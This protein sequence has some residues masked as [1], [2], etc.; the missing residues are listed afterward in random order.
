MAKKIVAIAVLVV[1]AIAVIFLVVF[2]QHNLN[3][4]NLDS[5]T[6][7]E[8]TPGELYYQGS[9]YT[10]KKNQEV[11]LLIGVDKFADDT[12]DYG[13]G[14]NAV[15]D[16]QLLVIFDK[17]TDETT[18][19]QLNRDTMTEITE[20]GLNNVEVGT[21][22]EQLALAYTYGSGGSDSCINIKKAVSNL[23]YGINIDYYAAITMD[24]LHF[25]NDDHG[26]VTLTVM[27]DLTPYDPDLEEGKVVTLTGTQA[28][29][30]VR[31]RYNV[32]DETNLHR[33]ERQQQYILALWKLAVEKNEEDSSF[34]LNVYS[35][36]SSYLTTNC[37]SSTLTKLFKAVGDLD[38]SEILTID[39]ENVQGETYM[40]Y[41]VDED[42]LQAMVVDLFYDQVGEAS[43]ENV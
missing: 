36:I 28:L 1:L 6:D 27:D 43:E 19:L 35:D 29:T 21:T 15:A 20:L 23:L 42:A 31:A 37:T 2:Y 33:M 14:N 25:I 13:F 5:T 17:D 8:G 24:A 10:K 12:V 9:W 7:E 40:E 38:V 30:Y 26:G 34:L 4:G 32:A 22:E 11:I 16:F 41:Y 3:E 39:G 18:A